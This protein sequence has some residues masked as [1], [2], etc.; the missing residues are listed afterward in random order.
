MVGLKT[1]QK[2]KRKTEKKK[3]CLFLIFNYLSKLIA[4][5]VDF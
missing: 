2:K 1:N 3:R 4:C 5:L